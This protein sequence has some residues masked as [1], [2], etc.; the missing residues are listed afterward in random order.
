ME[1]G[2]LIDEARFAE[3]E[4]EFPA[5]VVAEVIATFRQTTP[6][7][8][9]LL[10]QA[11]H[12]GDADAV[13]RAAHRLRGGCMV[14]GA[15]AVERITGRLEAGGGVAERSPALVAAEIEDVWRRTDAEL[16]RRA[17]GGWR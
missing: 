1:S 9:E 10:I 3:L 11:V 4:S 13:V 12:A 6:P 8:V 16:A 15:S 5:A 2:E 17:T 14:I 7:L